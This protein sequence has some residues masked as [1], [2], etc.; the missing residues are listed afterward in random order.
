MCLY[1]Y[2]VSGRL[3]WYFNTPYLGRGFD[4]FICTQV[5]TTKTYLCLSIY[6]SIYFYLYIYI[7]NHQ[8]PIYLSTYLSIYL[9]IL[10][11]H[12]FAPLCQIPTRKED[13]VNIE[14]FETEL[15]HNFILNLGMNIESK[16]VLGNVTSRPFRKLWQS[17]QPS[18]RPTN[19]STD[20]PTIRQTDQPTQR[21]DVWGRR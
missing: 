2:Y 1:F 7:P 12:K 14:I 11:S 17:D 8:Y 19:H 3:C 5:F 18:N 10:Y 13:I 9:S 20:R 16:Q 15:S 4:T 21:M 6:Q